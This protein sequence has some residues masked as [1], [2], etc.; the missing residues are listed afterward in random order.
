[1]TDTHIEVLPRSVSKALRGIVF[2]L[3]A[4]INQNLA[5]YFLYVITI[6]CAILFPI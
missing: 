1:M 6:V 2:I 5:D 3:S 4:Q